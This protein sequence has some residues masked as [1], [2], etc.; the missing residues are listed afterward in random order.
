[1]DYSITAAKT[2]FALSCNTCFYDACEEVLTKP[3]WKQVNG[4][5]AHI[6]GE[7]PGAARYE[8]SM[9]EPERRAYDN[10]M[11][12]CPKHHKLVD[13]LEPDA[14]SVERLLK[15]KERH[16]AGCNGAKWASDER[17]DVIVELLIESAPAQ[18]S[19]GNDADDNL[20]A[21]EITVWRETRQPNGGGAAIIVENAGAAPA[22]W[23]VVELR[24][25]GSG[26]T[27]L[28][29]NDDGTTAERAELR[30]G[31]RWPIPLKKNASK[32]D[33]PLD[34]VYRWDD[35]REPGRHEVPFRVEAI[36]PS[37]L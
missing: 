18:Q 37:L 23:V 1:M 35:D 30:P 7:R 6:R 22:R 5:V 27:V 14:H 33:F 16:L 9:S 8:K 32:S 10:L 28:L 15:M 36:G 21:A 13:R 34:I 31:E 29:A 25:S 26:N 19:G 4:E 17:L 3:E 20:A 24:A 2:L 12:L 11:L